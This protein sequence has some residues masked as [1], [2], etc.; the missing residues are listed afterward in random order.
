MFTGSLQVK[1]Y[2]LTIVSDPDTRN[3]GIKQFYDTHSDSIVLLCDRGPQK[4]FYNTGCYTSPS[5]TG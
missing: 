3:G 4:R 1:F 5:D 2:N